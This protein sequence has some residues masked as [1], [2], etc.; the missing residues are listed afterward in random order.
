[1][2]WSAVLPNGTR[3]SPVGARRGGPGEGSI[4]AA[5]CG[6]DLRG[7][8]CLQPLPSGNV[9]I[10][11]PPSLVGAVVPELLN[12]LR[13]ELPGIRLRIF[14][15]FSEQIERWLSEGIVDVGIYSKYK[16]GAINRRCS[17]LNSRLVLAGVASRCDLP[18]EIDFERLVGFSSGP[19]GAHQWAQNGRRCRRT[20][21]EGRPHRRCR[22]RFDPCSEG[23][24][25][26]LRLLH[27]QGAAHD[28]RRKAQRN[29]FASSVI[30]NPYISRYVVLVTGQQ[31]PLSR[32]AREV[33]AR[34]T[35]ILRGL[36]SEA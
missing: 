17:V 11:L 28:R 22:S 15:G 6:A 36:S 14:E 35:L 10:G 25:A 33:A 20:A 31:K 16:E 34:V 13:R 7:P 23:D 29:F 19:A 32:A 18:A 1:M 30:R 2:G 9:S 21:H 8:A 27:D 24:G 3:R 12:Q 4:S 5:G 26:E